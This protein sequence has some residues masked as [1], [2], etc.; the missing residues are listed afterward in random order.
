MKSY[1]DGLTTLMTTMVASQA[2]AAAGGKQGDSQFLQYLIG[3]MKGMK[4]KM[5]GGGGDPLEQI[6]QY[7]KKMI[8][9]QEEMRTQFG[10]G[11][12]GAAG[13]APNIE[14]MKLMIEVEDRKNERAQLQVG[15]QVSEAEKQ[16]QYLSERD[17]LHRRWK[18]EDDKWNAELNIKMAQFNL[19][20]N[21]RK[22]SVDT[23][24]D[25]AGSFIASLQVKPEAASPGIAA[26]QAPRQEVNFP[27][28]MTC[29][30]LDPTTKEPCGTQFAWP[31]GQMS[32][33]CPKCGA[34]YNLKKAE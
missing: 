7:H 14:V 13:N 17:D 4:E 20:G 23:F 16:R 28:S 9:W 12:L 22:E 3:E 27:V 15:F 2:A 25:V 26:P 21:V 31:P 19:D 5:E 10:I 29:T 33:K 30:E 24:K 18:I 6:D 34:D 1:A 11:P 32:T 8:A